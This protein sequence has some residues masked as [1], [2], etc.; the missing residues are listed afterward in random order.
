VAGR[1]GTAWKLRVAAPPEDGRANE[2]VTALVAEALGVR[3]A[4]VTLVAG[5]SS[6]DKLVE[7]AGLT[8]EEVDRRLTARAGSR[9]SR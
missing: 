4:D 3:R 5:G 7:V 1:H 9:G 2:Q 6:R 8:A